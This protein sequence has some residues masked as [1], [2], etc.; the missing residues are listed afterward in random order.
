MLSVLFGL[1]EIFELVFV[2]LWDLKH[3][4]VMLW[5]TMMVFRWIPIHWRFPRPRHFKIMTVRLAVIMGR[6]E[7][8]VGVLALH[9]FD[10]LAEVAVY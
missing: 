10:G 4:L 8:L 5:L 1:I 7:G 3:T 2:I 6:V 9:A